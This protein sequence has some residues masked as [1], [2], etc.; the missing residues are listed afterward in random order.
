MS[1]R[2]AKLSSYC[3]ALGGTRQA[4]LS[5][6]VRVMGMDTSSY[7]AFYDHCHIIY[8]TTVSIIAA[9]YGQGAD[10]LPH[11]DACCQRVVHR[12]RLRR[13]RSADWGRTLKAPKQLQILVWGLLIIIVL[14]FFF[15]GGVL[16]IYYIC[17][18]W[19]PKPVSNQLLLRP[20]YSS[21]DT[22]AMCVCK[23]TSHFRLSPAGSM[24]D[25]S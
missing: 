6:F 19:A 5:R 1:S 13:H 18:Q 11:A 21:A 24:L 17:I 10:R 16:I 8:N 7:Y 4:P 25:S 2:P 15:G 23:R 20:L 14:F 9:L 22:Y 3:F 12:R